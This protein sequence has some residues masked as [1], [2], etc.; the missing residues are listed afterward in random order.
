[1]KTY[2]PLFELL[3]IAVVA[4]SCNRAAVSEQTEVNANDPMLDEPVI[5]GGYTDMNTS[6]WKE[7]IEFW[8]VG[9]EPY[10]SIDL[11][12]EGEF[13]LKRLGQPDIGIPA[14]AAEKTEYGIEYSGAS[15]SFDLVIRIYDEACT[16]N[17]SGQLFNHKVEVDFRERGAAEFTTYSGCGSYVNDV[18]LHNIWVLWE[19][20]GNPL[21]SN[22]FPKG[23]PY[24]ELNAAKGEILGFD[25]CNNF[26]GSWH[27]EGKKLFF[28]PIAST[29]MACPGAEE[30][31]YLSNALSDQHFSYKIVENE[32][33]IIKDFEIISRFKAGD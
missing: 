12:F 17:M 15:M 19:I 4:I 9:N 33:Q 26:S 1:M 5:E 11:D 31:G 7:G 3:L 23:V 10:W 2:H 22:Q 24:M 13:T 21:D 28:G 6:K 25:G 20:Y 30:F 29:K 16:D 18:Q 32:L 27:N 14:Q 8:A